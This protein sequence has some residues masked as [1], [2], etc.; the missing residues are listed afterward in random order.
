[1]KIKKK[2]KRTDEEM[3]KYVKYKTCTIK[4]NSKK[5]NSIPT[6]LRKYF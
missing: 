5:K 6:I 1:M 2:P 3:K 4:K